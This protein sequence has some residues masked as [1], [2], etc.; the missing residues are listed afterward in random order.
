MSR[1]R[2]LVEHV[3]LN[4]FVSSRHAERFLFDWTILREL[5]RAEHAGDDDAAFEWSR[6]WDICVAY[7]TSR[8]PLQ[9]RRLARTFARA[10]RNDW[11]DFFRE[12]GG[13]MAVETADGDWVMAPCVCGVC[14]AERAGVARSA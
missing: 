12:C 1:S 2:T 10:V 9:R 6:Y 3:L 7:R 14:T 8:D 5:E 11:T 13:V 4:S